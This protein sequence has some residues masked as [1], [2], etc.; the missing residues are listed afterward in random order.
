MKEGGDAARRWVVP[1]CY[2]DDDHD[3]SEEGPYGSYGN[4][5]VE[6]D[7]TNG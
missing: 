5:D 2:Q 3:S 4:Q 7:A 6:L 1:S